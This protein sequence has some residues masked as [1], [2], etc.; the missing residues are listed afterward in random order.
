V[1]R[2]SRLS[3]ALSFVIA[4]AFIGGAGWL[5]VRGVEKE[6]ALVGSLL[7]AASAV[8]AVAIS[9]NMEKRAELRQIHRDQM[10]PLYAELIDR[11]RT[12]IEDQDPAEA[13]KFW[14]GLASRLILFGPPSVIKA[15]LVLS[16]HFEQIEAPFAP[17]PK[18]MLLLERL[19]R[20]IRAD[21]G[22]DDKDLDQGDLLRLYITDIDEVIGPFNPGS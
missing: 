22:H 16:R 18:A 20:A 4:V 9:R 8:V 10:T 21:L 17:D 3:Q 5:I 6:P 1:S 2:S 12:A 19:Y 14:K 11:V 15:Q 13:E 7:T